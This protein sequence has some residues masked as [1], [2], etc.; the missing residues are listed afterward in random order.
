MLED[1]SIR[2]H[3]SSLQLPLSVFSYFSST[4]FIMSVCTSQ[5]MLATL[6]CVWA[7]YFSFITA[8][9][10]FDFFF[11]L[12]IFHQ[13]LLTLLTLHWPNGKCLVINIF[14]P[15]FQVMPFL[16]ISRFYLPKCIPIGIIKQLIYVIILYNSVFICWLG[17]S[18]G[19]DAVCLNV[20]ISRKAK[21]RES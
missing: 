3:T 18:N 16:V 17:L 6:R 12:F 4:P 5:R 1:I 9:I 7:R 15:F 11:Y 14:F 19:V 10:W 13:T 20:S 8:P 21:R 2:S